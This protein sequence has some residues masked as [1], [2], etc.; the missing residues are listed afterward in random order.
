M[1]TMKYAQRVAVLGLLIREMREK[2]SWTG[3]THIQKGAFL[4]Q[5]LMGVNLGLDFV[6]YRHGPFSFD[7]RDELSSMQ[8]DELL[9]LVLRREGY[10][11]SFIPTN[12]SET[13]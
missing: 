8:A 6:L 10:G 13:F 5:E 12:F 9:A 11:P 2:G 4:L 7:L 3:E 1:R